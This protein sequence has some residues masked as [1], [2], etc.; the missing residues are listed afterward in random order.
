MTSCVAR[1]SRLGGLAKSRRSRLGGSAKL[2]CDGGRFS[3]RVPLEFRRHRP[4]PGRL[5]GQFQPAIDDPPVVPLASYLSRRHSFDTPQSCTPSSAHH[6]RSVSPATTS[7]TYTTAWCSFANSPPPRLRSALFRPTHHP[8]STRQTLHLR[9]ERDCVPRSW[10]DM[11]WGCAS[12]YRH[13]RLGL[14]KPRFRQ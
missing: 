13:P 8:S 2:A 5:R 3:R 6:L 10:A 12:R 14:T 7:S 1:Q 9:N 4:P 11:T